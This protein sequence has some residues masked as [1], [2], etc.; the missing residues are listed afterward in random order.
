MCRAGCLVGAACSQALRGPAAHSTATAAGPAL[1]GAVTSPMFWFQ[2]QEEQLAPGNGHLQLQVRLEPSLSACPHCRPHSALPPSFLVPRCR[3][4]Q[5]CLLF[6]SCFVWLG[7]S[8]T[9]HL[10]PSSTPLS[11]LL[12]RAPA[13][14]GFSP[15]LAQYV[16]SA[17]LDHV[18]GPQTSPE[19]VQP[20]AAASRLASLP[21][22]LPAPP[23]L[24]TATASFA[25]APSPQERPSASSH[26]E[27]QAV[28]RDEGSWNQPGLLPGVRGELPQLLLT[29]LSR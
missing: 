3:K 8:L 2:N 16:S 23:D 14:G 24:C 4:T 28:L 20:G 9:Q 7:L 5:L 22:H 10:L 17:L 26:R 6:L 11:H 25:L 1:Q 27:L 29:S 21:G 18:P 13:A 19:C 12:C 15:L